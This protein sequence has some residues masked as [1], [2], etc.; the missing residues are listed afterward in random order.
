VDLVELS[1]LSGGQLLIF[2]RYRRER[3]LD[4]AGEIL[5]AILLA[6]FGSSVITVLQ[7]K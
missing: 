3:R 4:L 6:Y 1:E 5:G 2:G 7:E